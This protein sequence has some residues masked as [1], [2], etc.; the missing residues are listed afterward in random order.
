MGLVLELLAK[1]HQ[2]FLSGLGVTIRL[3]LI[4]WI[5]GLLVG[6]GLGI[7]SAQ[8]R[9]VVGLPMRLTA[10]FLS[11]IPVLI[12]LFWAHYPLQA[13][14]GVVIDP[15]ITAAA[16]LSI[17]NVLAVAELLRSQIID[18]PSQYEIAARVCGLSRKT[19]LLRILIPLLLRRVLPALLPLQIVMLHSSLFASLIS[20]EEIFRVSQHVNALE[21]K[22]VH[23]Y[24]ALALF[25]LAISLPVNALAIWLH[26]RFT[27]NT[28]E[29]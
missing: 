23:I 9:F 15:F 18:F 24:T 28:A 22:P 13:I 21:Y 12:F 17:V 2:A 3:T 4:I 20:V 26:S 16:V 25:F 19:F 27:R 29:Q 11:G 8:H 14:L 6:T 5:I 10:F 1:Y 7:L